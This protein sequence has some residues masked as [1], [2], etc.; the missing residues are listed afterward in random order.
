MDKVKDFLEK[1][2]FQ[3]ASREPCVMHFDVNELELRE[4]F[5]CVAVHSANS[6]GKPEPAE[7]RVVR[8]IPSWALSARA[9]P[10]LIY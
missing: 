9:G 1:I 7:R 3:E 5:W 8:E 10:S 2:A 6:P 4:W